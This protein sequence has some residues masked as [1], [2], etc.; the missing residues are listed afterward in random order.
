M[1]P[2]REGAKT[3]SRC[4]R[5]VQLTNVT[6][7]GSL[8]STAVT[9]DLEGSEDSNCRPYSAESPAQSEYEFVNAKGDRLGIL[10]CLI[11]F[12][13]PLLFPLPSTKFVS[14][15]VTMKK[16]DDRAM[17]FKQRIRGGAPKYITGLGDGRV[18]DITHTKTTDDEALV[19]KAVHARR[20]HHHHHQPQRQQH[21][22]DTEPVVVI[23]PEGASGDKTIHIAARNVY[24]KQHHQHGGRHNPN[25]DPWESPAMYLVAATIIVLISAV[26]VN[27]ITS[28]KPESGS[29]KSYH[30][31]H[32][33]KKRHSKI[34]K[35][36]TDEWNEDAKEVDLLSESVRGGA[37][38]PDLVDEAGQPSVTPAPYYPYQPRLH[39]EHRHR[40]NS[41]SNSSVV[42]ATS[43]QQPAGVP[44]RSYYLNQSGSA[45]IA[46]N[47]Y[48]SARCSGPLVAGGGNQRL[49]AHTGACPPSP[50]PN[51]NMGAK[52]PLLQPLL[53]H[54]QKT[55]QLPSVEAHRPHMKARPMSTTASSF[56]SL[57]EQCSGDEIGLCSSPQHAPSRG[58]FDV[59]DSKSPAILST[60]RRPDDDLTP[61]MGQN[62]GKRLRVKMSE[63]IDRTPRATNGR[64]TMYP[65]NEPVPE[66]SLYNAIHPSRED[67]Q[68]PSIMHSPLSADLDMLFARSPKLRME[69]EELQQNSFIPFVPSLDVHANDPR[70]PKSMNVDQLHLFQLMESGNVSHWEERVAE[71]SRQLQNR[72]FPGGEP[73]DNIRDSVLAASSNMSSGST[74]EMI[75]SNDPHKGIKHKR[76]DLTEATD[77]ASSLQ[78]AIDFI[79]LKL[80]DVIGG[81]GFG[82]VWKAFWR[83]T[84][85]AV[86]VLTGSAQSK[87]V[88]LSVLEEFAAEIN[89]LKGMRHPNICLYMGACLEPPNR[90]IITELAANGSLWDALRLPLSPP[91]VPCDGVTRQGWPDSLYQP[92][93]R[94]GAPPTAKPISL[95]TIPPKGSWHWILTKRVACGAARG[96]SYLH[97]GKIPVLHRDLKSANIL[98]DESYTAK[99]CDFGLSRLKAQERSMT[100]NCGTVQWMVRHSGLR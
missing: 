38:R 8:L 23:F 47:S 9:F 49:V 18:E 96:L 91:Y 29:V 94:H 76:D 64:L 36:K 10:V 79:E 90:A 82:Q 61:K 34:R 14:L 39:L 12:C 26:F 60:D 31:Y 24:N 68:P 45:V 5:T 65:M 93:A 83:G 51:T 87:A 43:P 58:D 74:I 66:H 2:T 98:L 11:R 27:L 17:L 21:V 40:K 20:S 100:G 22:A 59:A 77:A 85:V 70:P 69:K 46:G 53:T 84:P 99:V 88:P 33:M 73:V 89:L 71:E 56:E 32:G 42:V 37:A 62:D 30:H 80:V 3:L 78:G 13:S 6:A 1:I 55:F 57:T 67:R 19:Q 4:C 28:G 63:L 92:D 72:I 41:S 25:P 35:K 97:G 95:T 48:T 16:T 75:P 7:H 54:H 81:G 15:S 50:L 86:K 44:T 52:D